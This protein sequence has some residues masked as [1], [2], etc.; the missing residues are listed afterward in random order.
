MQLAYLQRREYLALQVDKALQDGSVSG[1]VKQALTD[2]KS[3]MHDGDK[4]LEAGDRLAAALSKE[5]RGNQQ[6]EHLMEMRD[7]FSKKSVWIIGGDGWAYDIGYGGL[8][9]VLAMNHDV[10]MLVLDTEVYSNTGGQS[11]KASPTGAV[12][13]FAASGKKTSKKN[14]AI[15]A[16]NY[17]YVYVAQVAL[18]A[19]MQQAV[20]AFVEAESFPGPSI[21]IAYASCINHGISAGMGKSMEEMNRAVE[22]GYWPIFR[23]DPRRRAEGKNPFQLDC[24]EPTLPL[25]DFLKGEVRYR[26]LMQSN[27][28]EATKLQKRL[29]EECKQRLRMYQKFAEGDGII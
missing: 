4:S 13:K 11:S 1:A 21:I 18:G 5:A 29:E 2:W 24:K 16:M 7:L 14:L 15:M 3:V 10:N 26:T 6:L 20:K 22:S 25:S 27:P 12:A 23:Y 19:K 8:D 17:G 28:E 9:H